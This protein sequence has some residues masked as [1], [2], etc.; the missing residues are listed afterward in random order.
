MNDKIVSE[1]KDME[2]ANLK[3]Q[4]NPHF[5]FNTLNNI[6]ALIQIDSAKAQ[7]A[8][9]QLSKMLRYALYEDFPEVELAKDLA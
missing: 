6:Y 7:N 4:L 8:V 3:N 1:Q 2:L 5:L 9:H